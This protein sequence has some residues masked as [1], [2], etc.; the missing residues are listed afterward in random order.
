[1]S[2]KE[3]QR[4]MEEIQEH[5]RK[6]RDYTSLE[7]QIRCLNNRFKALNDGE[8]DEEQD[9]KQHLEDQAA[10]IE[11]LKQILEDLRLQIKAKKRQ[12]DGLKEHYIQ[13]YHV[14]GEKN[15]ELATLRGDTSKQLTSN[16]QLEAEIQE[17]KQNN[18]RLLIEKEDSQELR[19]KLESQGVQFLNMAAKYQEEIRQ[20]EQEMGF[21]DKELKENEYQVEKLLQDISQ[22]RQVLEESNEQLQEIQ[23]MIDQLKSK[24]QE[25]RKQEIEMEKRVHQLTKEVRDLND[26][27]SKL[28]K[29]ISLVKDTAVVKDQELRALQDGFN[30]EKQRENVQLNKRNHLLQRIDEMNVKSQAL[31]QQQYSM[32][33]QLMEFLDE[34]ERISKA[35]Y[36]RD[37]EA[38]RLRDRNKQVLHQSE[39]HLRQSSKSPRRVY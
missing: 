33:K 6:E 26:Q 24:N 1:M 5:R 2:E 15:A 10:E 36:D 38:E 19:E 7:D 3:I 8:D 30:N 11:H 28:D 14:E 9:L 12:H 4:M 17:Y 20:I 23:N 31:E 37:L 32:E 27:K 22:K 25:L 16:T 29:E 18:Q 34:N 21:K 13:L 35:L 39:I